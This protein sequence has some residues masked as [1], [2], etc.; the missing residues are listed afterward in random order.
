MLPFILKKEIN[1]S[2]MCGDGE[3]E[4]GKWDQES[5]ENISTIHFYIFVFE[6]YDYYI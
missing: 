2:L 3:W 1:S 5:V 4:V 6:L